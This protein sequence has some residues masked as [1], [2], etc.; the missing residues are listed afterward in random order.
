MQDSDSQRGGRDRDGEREPCEEGMIISGVTCSFL[1]L[2]NSS[3]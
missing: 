2:N 1:S 3:S